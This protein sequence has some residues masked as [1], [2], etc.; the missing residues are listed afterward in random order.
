MASLTDWEKRELD[1]AI[2]GLSLE[3][4]DSFTNKDVIELLVL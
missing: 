4:Y 1:N 2:L 3:K